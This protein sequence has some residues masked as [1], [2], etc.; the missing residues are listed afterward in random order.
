MLVKKS[1][2]GEID[3]FTPAMAVQ[4]ELMSVPDFGAGTSSDDYFAAEK[5]H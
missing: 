3:L 4:K 2:K 1:M 5:K